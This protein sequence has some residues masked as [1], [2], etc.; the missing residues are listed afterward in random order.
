MPI[1]HPQDAAPSLPETAQLLV[2]GGDA[3]IALDPDGGANRYGC[4]PFPDPELAAF[5]SSTATAISAAGFAAADGLRNRV[6]NAAATETPDI[7]YERE[8]EHIRQ[9]LI[10]LCGI[11]DLPGL[12]AIFASSGTDLH[13][14]AGQLVGASQDRPT[15]AIMVE[16]AE[17]GSGVA[18]SLAADSRLEIAS[19]PIRHGDGTPRP[20]AQVD[21]E[22]ET[23]A[24]AAGAQGQRVLLILVDVSKTGL[25]AP[26]PACVARL[27]ALRP[28][29]IDVLVD[30]CQFR[31][32][33]ST[34]RAYLEQGFMVGLTGS[35]F[36]AGPTFS[37]VLLIPSTAAPHLRNNI[38]RPALPGSVGGTNP[39]L[40]LRWEAALTEL[41]AFRALPENAVCDFLRDFA[42]AVRN[43][44]ATDPLFELL[45]TPPLDRRPLVAATRWDAIP[46][47]F[48]FLLY[49]N[50]SQSGRK[51]LN[52]EETTRISRLL[53]LDLS[54]EG[55]FSSRETAALRCQLGQPVACGMRDGVTVSAL[56]LCVSAR[57]VV[58]ATKNDGAAAV[59]GRALM[60]LDKTAQLAMRLAKN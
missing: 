44:L 42:Q 31:I 52:A 19:V 17:T 8:F 48:P 11:A 4:T 60:A 6:L 57:L 2:A 49:R 35:K 28:E 47:I 36:I 30:A 46:T 7:V 53:Q 5:G 55:Y 56:R 59:I 29:S 40:L 15:L 22:V 24:A 58:E 13:S 9:E 23:L 41:R 20:A 10:R 27:H 54:G 32:A 12:D 51:P 50:D 38:R 21:A 39:G 43:R 3:R 16:T 26:S 25:I 45:P 37:G 14:L 18:S 33:N 34:L 1:P